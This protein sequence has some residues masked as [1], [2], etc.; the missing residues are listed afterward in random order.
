[1]IDHVFIPD[2]HRLY[3]F[4]RFVGHL[5]ET[6]ASHLR[7]TY[8]ERVLLHAIRG[9]I[10]KTVHRLPQLQRLHVY[11]GTEHPFRNI[12]PNQPPIAKQGDSKVPTRHF[13]I[14]AEVREEIWKKAKPLQADQK[15]IID[16]W[17][18]VRRTDPEAYT[19]VVANAEVRLTVDQYRHYMKQELARQREASKD[20]II[21][22]KY[23][24]KKKYNFDYL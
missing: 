10:P 20:K 1:M 24:L 12:F 13:Q 23:D 19:S 2:F 18:N 22:H 4:Y 7:E 14:P 5:N 15:G 6:K 17:D 16:F 3:V 8:P 9:M 11:A 21:T